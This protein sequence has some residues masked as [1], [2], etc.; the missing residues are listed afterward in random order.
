MLQEIGFGISLSAVRIGHRLG[1]VWILPRK[2]NMF[3]WE[4]S[5]RAYTRVPGPPQFPGPQQAHIGV[6][7]LNELRTILRYPN[8]IDIRLF[9][10][11][12]ELWACDATHS[13]ADRDGIRNI[14]KV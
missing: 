14:A 6:G 3:R 13:L 7:I 5:G 4:S 11:V 1:Q 10:Y 12:T 8:Y 9:I 2:A